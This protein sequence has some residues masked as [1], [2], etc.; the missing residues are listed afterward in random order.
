M[1]SSLL[2]L[3]LILVVLM[4]EQVVH[5][6]GE[7]IGVRTGSRPDCYYLDSAT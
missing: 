5:R 3:E 6:C 7:C 2:D 1:L 4:W